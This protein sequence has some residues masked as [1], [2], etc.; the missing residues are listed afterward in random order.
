MQIVK[1][2]ACGHCEEIE[3]GVAGANGSG[4][5]K[6]KGANPD[7]A[8]SKKRINRIRGQ[9]DAVARM[10]DEREYCPDIIQQIRAATSAMKSLES[11]ILRGHLRGCVREAF[12]SKDGFEI[13]DKIDEILNLINR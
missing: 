13:H 11:E 9:L 8:A 2:G 10:I 12:E 5:P 6:T 3:P 4:E 1:D 7:H